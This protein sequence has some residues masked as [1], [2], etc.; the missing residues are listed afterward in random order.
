MAN[1]HDDV[2]PATI[3]FTGNTV[4]ETVSYLTAPLTVP[5]IG[6]SITST[7]GAA[8]A[9]VTYTP[10]G[11]CGAYPYSYCRTVPCLQC[12]NGYGPHDISVAFWNYYPVDDGSND[13]RYRVYIQ[14]GNGNIVLLPFG[15]GVI[16]SASGDC[17]WSA[18]VPGTPGPF[19]TQGVYLKLFYSSGWK[20]NV[21][22]TLDPT[23]LTYIPS[24]NDIDLSLTPGNPIAP[25]ITDFDCLRTSN[26]STAQVTRFP[27]DADLGVTVYGWTVALGVPTVF[28]LQ[29]R[30]TLYSPWAVELLSCGAPTVLTTCCADRVPARLAFDLPACLL[31]ADTPQYLDW[32]SG[33]K[34]AGPIT[35]NSRTYYFTVTCEAGPHWRLKIY[36]GTSEAATLVVN[37][38]ETSAVCY[39]IYLNW[40]GITL[41]GWCGGGAFD[42]VLT[43]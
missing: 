4:S 14:W 42:L 16:L 38:T 7:H 3:T 24:G 6:S 5:W 30:T 18:F 40:T 2:A 27:T 29:D 35:S 19:G 39:P 13:Y 20:I 8:V 15:F 25:T 34:W 28:P 10:C 43:A 36:D 9:G 17:E 33:Y 32:Q 26:P 22:Y 37:V 23:G 41:T 1:A 31:P 21:D 11:C 12:T